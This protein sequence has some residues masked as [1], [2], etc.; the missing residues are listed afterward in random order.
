MNLL[1]LRGDF[2]SLMPFIEQRFNFLIHKGMVVLVMVSND[3][4]LWVLLESNNKV[5]KVYF[6]PPRFYYFLHLTLNLFQMNSRKS[7]HK[8]HYTRT[9]LFLWLSPT[10]S[11]FISV[12]LN[13]GINYLPFINAAGVI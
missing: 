12:R 8:H 7:Y 11:N 10:L 5:Q 2:V 4:F 3:S 13:T 1:R 6:R 9:Y